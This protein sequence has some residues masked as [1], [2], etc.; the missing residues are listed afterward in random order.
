MNPNWKVTVYDLRARGLTL[1][2]ERLGTYAAQAL[3]ITYYPFDHQ[4]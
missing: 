3:T 4:A 1:E 2:R